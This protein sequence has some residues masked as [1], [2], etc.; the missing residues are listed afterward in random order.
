MDILQNFFDKC[1]KYFSIVAKFYETH[2]WHIARLIAICF[3]FFGLL[4]KDLFLCKFIKRFNTPF[5]INL[6]NH[7]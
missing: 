6:F 4:K 3:K 5:K 2:H 7:V 1:D